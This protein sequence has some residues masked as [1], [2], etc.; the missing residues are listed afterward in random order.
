[1][2]RLQLRRRHPCH[3]WKAFKYWLKLGFISFGG[4][5][6]QISHDASGTGER[7]AGISEQ[8]FMHGLNYCMM[9]P[10][11]KRQQL[12]TYIG[13]LMHGV[14]GGITAGVAV[15]TAFANLSLVCAD[16]GL[17]GLGNLP[18]VA[19]ILYGIQACGHGHCSVCGLSHRLARA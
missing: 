5:A 19:G 9:L 2:N 17:P 4:P 16:V 7:R 13:W 18:A 11:P 3:F 15:C 12:A 14:K 1:M 8:R 10:G 6:G